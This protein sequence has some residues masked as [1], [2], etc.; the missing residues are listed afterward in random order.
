MDGDSLKLFFHLY[1]MFETRPVVALAV[2]IVWRH[3]DKLIR[4]IS[5]V[6]SFPSVWG[7][8]FLVNSRATSQRA[9]EVEYLIT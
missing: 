2:V 8:L 7:G 4:F 1:L 3:E 9:R 5:V 6:D